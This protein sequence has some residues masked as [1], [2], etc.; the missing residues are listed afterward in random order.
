MRLIHLEID[1][2]RVIRR[3]RLALPDHIIGV[4]GP[5]GAGKSSLIEAVAWALYG[6]QAARTGREEIKAVYAEP[7]DNCRVRLEFQIRE[8]KYT[9]ERRL[10]GKSERAEVELFRGDNSESVGVNETKAYVGQLLGLDWKGF[11]TSFLARQQEL[12]ALSDLQAAKRQDHL[13]AMLGIE[14]LDQ[15][16]KLVKDD[17]RILKDRVGFL[18]RQTASRGEIERVIKG[19]EDQVAEIG[20]AISKLEKDHSEARQNQKDASEKLES[21]Q[22][23]QTRFNE[24]RARQTST[25]ATLDRE[26]RRLSNLQ[27][28]RSALEKAG[29][30]EKKLIAE[31]AGIAPVNAEVE[32]L[33]EV[34]SRTTV[35]EEW[36]KQLGIAGRDHKTLND[37]IDEQSRS[38]DMIQKQLTEF[39][40]DI[41]DQLRSLTKEIEAAIEDHRRHAGLVTSL[42]RDIARLQKQLED[43]EQFGPESVCER[44][45][46]PLGGDLPK[47][48]GH[49][50]E[51]LTQ[52][53]GQLA[54]A[55][56]TV[57]AVKAAGSKLREQQ[58]ASKKA[59][60]RRRDLR[61]ELKTASEKKQEMQTRLD[62]LELT[63]KQFEAD[64]EH[65]GDTTFD[66]A[67]F[68]GLEKKLKG[69]QA[70]R[71]KL[72]ELRGKL[73][74][75]PELEKEIAEA[76]KS[77]KSSRDE[78][79][80]IQASLEK[81]SF[82]PEQFGKTRQAFA[83]AQEK[84]EDARDNLSRAQQQRELWQRE[85]SGKQEQM[86]ALE[87]ATEE[88]EECR[89]GH[90]HKEKLS[91]LFAQYRKHLIAT[92]R[93]AL[94]DSASRLISEMTNGKYNLI[95]L[96][97]QY[98]LS[99][100]D[101][102][103]YYG[104][105]RFSGG[106]KDL[107]NLC[108]RMAISQ[109]LTE[110]AG[111]DRSFVILDEVFGSQDE[112]R[113]ELIVEALK[114]LKQSFPQVLLVTHIEEL[115]DRVEEVIEV[116][117][118]QAGHSEVYLNGT[119]T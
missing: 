103:Q 72:G 60:D 30:E 20:R 4:I 110:S 63:I 105:D 15:A 35:V 67:R 52:L 26:H 45:H 108:L 93:P 116:R 69:L 66:A 70:K 59:F 87:K 55:K 100:F 85:L 71:E 84:F 64:L 6:N 28:E 33:R 119:L 78:A 42:E 34:R 117:P 43:V 75:L 96:D 7:G 29:D 111:L 46:R 38:F 18:E 25:T 77:V 12:N 62:R 11:L 17:T 50:N 114:N 118:T 81:L 61:R 107:A 89:G 79:A 68:N 5:N 82:S 65:E 83:E 44:C 21:A 40:E 14:R 90:Y 113:R 36:R 41:E 54:R 22:G 104:I 1:Q 95:E 80:Q 92:I 39:P 10:V 48:K 91:S 57:E 98:N 2:F 73:S 115:K 76:E 9:V 58:E 37:Q 27:A 47:I 23:A 94:S 49:I 51:E 106:E 99:V 8:E 13:A 53:V 109:A 102:G 24:L 86:A 88:L 101:S 74:R 16:I 31:T 32:K 3:A 112:G 97:A 19:L 56:E